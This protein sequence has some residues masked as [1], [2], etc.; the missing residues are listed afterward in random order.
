M[1][2]G[3]VLHK[4]DHGVIRLS[5][6]VDCIAS[7]A[8]GARLELSPDPRRLLVKEVS[9]LV[10]FRTSRTLSALGSLV[11]A[12]TFVATFVALPIVGRTAAVA[13]TMSPEASIEQRVQSLVPSLEH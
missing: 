8:L 13:E 3:S 5:L 2:W 7:R 4:T 1:L 6:P 11:W 12:T 10:T 9:M